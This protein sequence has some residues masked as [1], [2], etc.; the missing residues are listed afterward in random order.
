[1]IGLVATPLG[2]VRAFLLSRGVCS[3]LSITHE[4]LPI[5]GAPAQAAW[6]WISSDIW[7]WGKQGAL[8]ISFLA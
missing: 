3:Q 1:V 4:A 6:G 2:N 8:D 5:S 7:G